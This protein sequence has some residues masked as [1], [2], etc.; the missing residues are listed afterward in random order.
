M[1]TR[2]R[3]KKRNSFVAGLFSFLVPGLGQIYNAQFTC[4]LILF[5]TM[6]ALLYVSVFSYL[7][8]YPIGAALIFFTAAAIYL[9][10]IFQSV[11]K[12]FKI[13]KVPLG[14]LNH[15]LVYIAIIIAAIFLNVSLY[16]TDGSYKNYQSFSI[17]SNSMAPTLADG[18]FVFID[19]RSSELDY[20]DVVV[21]K[22]PSQEDIFYIKRVIGLP[23]DRIQYKD[24]VL[25]LNGNIVQ[26]TKIGKKQR[27]AQKKEEYIELVKY[28]EK[29]PG[30]KVINIYEKN[31]KH[32]LDNT[33]EFEVPKDHVFMLGDNRDY[34]NDSRNQKLVGFIPYENVIGKSLYIYWS[35]SLDRFGKGIN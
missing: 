3:I 9:Y 34:S 10:A 14:R 7:L 15:P 17:P 23:G 5:V 8:S 1:T 32:P 18:D 19:K 30:G 22:L 31:D 25:L 12:A 16:D 11:Y 24:G 21:F 33:P 26:R 28:Q 6:Y 29:L 27:I 35:K 13:K 2:G 4:G 20:G